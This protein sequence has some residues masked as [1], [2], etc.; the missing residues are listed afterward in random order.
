MPNESAN[1]GLP[2]PY[3]TA[4]WTGMSRDDILAGLRAGSI[5]PPAGATR[6]WRPD[7]HS[8]GETGSGAA[9]DEAAKVDRDRVQGWFEAIDP[10]LPQATFDTIWARAGTDDAARAETLTSYLESLLPNAATDV[11]KA[12]DAFV[13]DPAHRA[14]VVDLSA[15]TGD[16]LAT[17]AKHD[18]GYRHALANLHPLALTGNRALLAGVNADGHLDRF[19][20][21]SGEA[22]ISD[23]WLAD[24]GK[25]LAWKTAQESGTAMAVAGSEDWTFV[26]R[27][28]TGSDGKPLAISIKTG[29]ADAGQNQVVFG[30]EDA[31]TLKGVSGSDRIYAGGGDDVVRGGAGGDHLEGGTGDDLVI[32]GRGDDEVAGNQGDDELEGGAGH[33]VLQGGAGDDVLTGGRGNDRLEG[34]SGDDTYVVD[35]GDGTDT[36]V[37]ADGVG[38]IELDGA[39]VSGTMAAGEGKWTSADGRLE[40]ELA[41]ETG[42][43]GTLTIKAFE[44]TDRGAAPLNVIE[45]R[46]WKNGD[47]GITLAGSAAGADSAFAGGPNFSVSG[48]EIS[49]LSP[50]EMAAFAGEEAS[51]AMAGTEASTESLFATRSGVGEGA[52]AES[53]DFDSALASLLGIN[54]S[55]FSALDP[56]TVQS[57]MDAFSGVLEPP[58]VAFGA[59]GDNGGVSGAVTDADVAEAL[60]GDVSIDDMESETSIAQVAALRTPEFIKPIDDY[61]SVIGAATN[62]G[63]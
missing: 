12:I 1:R 42:E 39:E 17:L 3:I 19:D 44:G 54:D 45:V 16:E 35:S 61:A 25:F 51:A 56:A 38:H 4:V 62:Q 15:T 36:I 5:L 6:G 49:V 50:A 26:D 60:A 30:N 58:D 31:E 40:F 22:L 21:D 20:P 28:M 37:D 27:G 7:F 63:R 47:L 2:I 41:G 57:A 9:D 43:P 53:F 14:K 29:A 10:E 32:G 23:A 33:D 34:G 8:A 13:A 48:P 59:I 55:G 52:M 24:R 18:A 11:A 46:N